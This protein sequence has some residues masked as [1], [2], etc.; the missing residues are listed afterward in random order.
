MAGDAGWLSPAG[1]HGARTR[2]LLRRAWPTLR[3]VGAPGSMADGAAPAAEPAEEPASEKK[4][5][6]KHRHKHRSDKDK[7]GEKS[8]RHKHKHKHRSDKDGSESSGGES[9]PEPDRSKQSD[10]PPHRPEDAAKAEPR[11]GPRSRSHSRSRSPRRGR[12][13]SPRGRRSPSP[14]GRRSRSQNERRRSPPPCDRRPYDRRPYD[15]PRGRYDRRSPP[16]RYGDRGG[17]RGGRRSPPR[18]YGDRSRSRSPPRGYRRRSRSRSPPIKLNDDGPLP[19]EKGP[20]PIRAIAPPATA[21]AATSAR[22]AA[23]SGGRFWDGFQWVDN[24]TGVNTSWRPPA[25]TTRKDRRIYIGNLPQ[26]V[27]VTPS[28]IQEFLNTTMK[29]AGIAPPGPD[30]VVS[31]WIAPEASYCFV[32]FSTPAG[33]FVLSALRGFELWLATR[34]QARSSKPPFR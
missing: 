12:S 4:H 5:K 7:S 30:P 32:E 25:P 34:V 22:P 20:R 1:C 10:L 13:L 33:T 29:A 3:A 17:D 8:H 27:G 11:G 31:V 16:R 15:G 9:S 26:N 19:K 28:M 21:V 2:R 23:A 24:S 18:R 14:H 6:H